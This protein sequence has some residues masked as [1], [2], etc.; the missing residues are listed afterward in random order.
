MGGVVTI[1]PTMYHL[2]NG[3][4]A[5]PAELLD[6]VR[7]GGG[8]RRHLLAFT[9][10]PTAAPSLAL[11]LRV[12]APGAIVGALLAEWLATGDGLGREMIRGKASFDYTTVWAS[13]ALVALAGMAVYG[14]AAVIES[15]VIAHWAPERRKP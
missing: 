4:D 7:A 6:V 8:R 10:L 5:V 11:S 3:L 1:V 14:V 13:T 2:M 15:R 9:Q 12:A